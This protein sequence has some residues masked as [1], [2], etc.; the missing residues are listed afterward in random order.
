MN[1]LDE[2]AARLGERFPGLDVP[3]MRRHPAFRRQA[4]EAIAALG[5]IATVVAEVAGYG[6]LGGAVN[7]HAV[8]VGRLGWCA[9]DAAERVH[10]EAARAEA[11][12]E[13]LLVRAAR[14]G[15][16]LRQLVAAGELALDD[17][18]E[19]LRSE[20]ARD[21]ERHAVALA[22]LPEGA[23]PALTGAPS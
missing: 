20:L 17:A 7:P 12:R 4:A 15:A 16:F 10:T 18:E 23:L 8:I 6:D 2:L 3:K 11:K 22:A 19:V 1:P 5:S 13:A 14:R 21:P 9:T